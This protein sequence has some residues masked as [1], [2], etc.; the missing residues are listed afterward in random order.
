MHYTCTTG[1]DKKGNMGRRILVVV[2]LLIVATFAYMGY[3]SSYDAKRAGANGEVFSPDSTTG[4]SNADTLPPP[5]SAPPARPNP[6]PAVDTTPV[7]PDQP[8]PTPA[9]AAATAPTGGDTINPNPPNG[10]AFSGTGRYQIYRQG[11]LTWRVNTDTG[12]SCIL[13]ATDE[14]W[15]KPKVYRAGCG[16]H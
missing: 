16:S 6:V 9:P 7:T 12:H 15:K 3:K 14:E 1:P 11:N 8:A 4:E 5:D 13:F 2:L 10:M